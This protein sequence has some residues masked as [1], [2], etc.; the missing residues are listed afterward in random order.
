M[1]KS[2]FRRYLLITMGIA[3][4]LAVSSWLL[5]MGF[6]K[7]L[8]KVTNNIVYEIRRDAFDHLETLSLY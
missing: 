8:A 7:I 2:I 4:A 5:A 6:K 1:Q 3:T